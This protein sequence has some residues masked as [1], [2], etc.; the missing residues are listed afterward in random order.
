MLVKKQQLRTAHKVGKIQFVFLNRNIKS[1]PRGSSQLI[2][3][4]ESKKLNIRVLKFG[5]TTALVKGNDLTVGDPGFLTRGRRMPPQDL[6]TP[7]YYLAIF[8]LKLH[9][10]ERNGTHP[11]R[12]LDPS[13]TCTNRG[14]HQPPG[15][16]VPLK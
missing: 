1:P 10:N 9:E 14:G 12:P 7:N 8:L 16:S 6:L 11:Y 3:N 5:L 2:M 15:L 4:I 13:I